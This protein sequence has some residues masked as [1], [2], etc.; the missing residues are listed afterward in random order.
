MPEYRVLPEIY[1]EIIIHLRNDAV[2][3]HQNVPAKSCNFCGIFRNRGLYYG[4]NN[5][6][7]VYGLRAH[8]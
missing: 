4:Y 8:L 1:S 3:I 5:P 6:D 7:E 2:M